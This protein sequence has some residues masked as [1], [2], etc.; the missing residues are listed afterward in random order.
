M[1]KVKGSADDSVSSN[2]FPVVGIGASAG[3]LEAISQFL[4]AIPK[5]SGMA[6]VFVQHLSPNHTS[7]LPEILRKIS[8]IPVHQ[9]TNNIHLEEDNF[10]IIPANKILTSTDGVL[11]L[12]PLD[13]KHF[14]VKI[15]DLFFSSLAVV[16]QSYA[17]GVILSGTM[18]DG[19]LGLEVIKA[20]GGI[21][22][23]Q[24]EASAAYD[25]MPKSAI[26]SGLV[27]F[28]LPPAEIVEHLMT[29]NHPFHTDYS[30]IGIANTTP[31]QDENVFK[32]ILTV[33]R[34]RRGVD[35]TYYKSSTLKRRIVRRMAI[36]RMEQPQDY[37][38]YLREHK[39]E[40][41][42]LYNDMLI[43][44]TD[45]FRD[46]VSFE[47]LCSIILPALLNQKS[48]NEP[49]RIWIAGCATGE[50]AYSFAICLQEFLGDK[51]A[52]IKIQIFATDI[53]ETAIAKART[54]IYRPSDINGL[55]PERRKR[56]FT[57]IDD[58]YLVNKNIRDMCIFAHHNLLKDPPF[59]KVDLISCRNV[60]IYLEPVLQKRIFNTFHYSL[61]PEGFLMLGK[62]E[63]I[64]KN[65]DLFNAYNN[66]ERIFRPNPLRKRFMQVTMQDHIRNFKNADMHVP[67]EGGAQ[68]VFK[69]ADDVILSKYVPAGVLI[70]ENFD[71]VQFRGITDPWLVLSPGK[72]S[73]NLLK[74]AREGL[75]FELRN[76]LHE[77]KRTNALARKENVLFRLNGA[78]RYVTIEVTALAGAL[79]L[80]YLIM[81]ENGFAADTQLPKPGSGGKK[82]ADPRDLRIE[83]LEKELVQSRADMRTVSEE[84]EAVN[85]ELQSA[86]EE[87]LSGSEELQSL[88]EELETSKEE[89]QST[90]EEINIVNSELLDRNEQ[91]N[92]SRSYTEAIINTIRDPLIIL[93]K[94]LKVKRATG[95]FYTKFKVTKKETEGRYFYDLGNKQWDIPALRELLESILP[96]KKVFADY[97]VTHVFPTI[98][99]RVMC[100]NTRQLDNVNGEQLI[101]LAIEDMTDKRK[102]EEGLAE[103]ELLFK[104]SKE[105]LKLAV[106]AAGLGTW[107]YSPL[108]DELILDQRSNDMLGLSSA[109]GID[110]KI[111]ISLIHDE[112]KGQL[113]EALKAAL[114][115]VAEGEFEREFRTAETKQNK[116]KWI[117]FK[118][119][120]YFT[121]RGIAYRFVGTSLDIT[122][123]KSHDESTLEL[124]KQK[125]DFISIASHELKTPITSLKASLQLISRMKDNPSP[126]ILNSLI[127]VSMRSL[128]RV[129]ILI[130]DL[131]N[132]SRFNQGHLHLNR[133]K[134]VLSHVIEDCCQHVR[135][136]GKYNII[137]TGELS[138]EVFA[139]GERIDQVMINFVN[140]AIK[141]APDM[142]DIHVVIEEINGMA[143]VSVIDRGPGIAAEKL[144][145]LFDRYYRVDTSGLQY[146]GLGLGLYICAEIIKKNDGEIGVDSV[147]GEGSTFWF[148]LP[149][150][151]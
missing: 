55:T 43:S 144:P 82:T 60:L 75:A 47:L 6:Y 87:M 133:T 109:D 132:A 15:I 135:M 77:V 74:M 37:L 50:E 118:G 104:E 121:Q 4:K 143:K 127:D 9:I 81:F 97:E 30:D 57:K 27:D 148:T 36:A 93:D 40:Q 142:K 2:Q 139:D 117:K 95:G 103:V 79:D 26:S 7:V 98:G 92:N 94:N 68:D 141:Y 114:A 59:S 125:D 63:S 72:A 56:F 128:D 38:V 71:I 39:K 62:S 112:D 122:S 80:H 90:N 44:V 123:Q 48:P 29:I 106:E 111:F 45:F 51:A 113:D 25:G 88:N 21:T 130:E 147:E 23:A 35:F 76:L 100:V 145:H 89:L 120:A 96:E 102:V 58:N 115:G 149:L 11:Q 84:Q 42:A 70:N 1:S 134:F 33:L 10:Y 138:L 107:D 34:V 3:G 12:A 116:L 136:G 17:V 49:L 126:K 28:V 53:S 46:P 67:K 83:Q 151:D 61:N 22:F 19:T 32:Q 86:N 137:T 85:E 105:R 101:I 73:L 124:L 65:E 140:N 24:D 18:T 52:L 20:Y 150:A 64:G 129:G 8:K 131:L 66:L 14:K 41:D 69:L 146:S 13:D 110:Y 16:H 119:K 108:N 99:R 5:K 78:Q 54:G 31:E 91:L